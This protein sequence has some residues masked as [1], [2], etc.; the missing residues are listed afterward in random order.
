VQRARRCLRPWQSA[1]ACG[2]MAVL[3]MRW[4]RS[5]WL[6]WSRY[7]PRH[8]VSFAVSLYLRV[9]SL[10]SSTL[11]FENSSSVQLPFNFLIMCWSLQHRIKVQFSTEGVRSQGNGIAVAG[12]RRLQS[13]VATDIHSPKLSHRPPEQAVDTIPPTRG[14]C[15]NCLTPGTLGG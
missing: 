2:W 10:C 15:L 1:V 12:H 11:Y 5:G 4:S 14:P 13:R 9:F 7:L 3:T 8:V 6:E